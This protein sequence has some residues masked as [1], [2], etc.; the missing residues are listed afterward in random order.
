MFED[1]YTKFS[2]VR[3]VKGDVSR[4]PLTDVV[5]FKMD[6]EL[7]MGY[8]FYHGMEKYYGDEAREKTDAIKEEMASRLK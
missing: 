4:L 8:V 2:R 5:S 7:G 6:P 1:F 3:L